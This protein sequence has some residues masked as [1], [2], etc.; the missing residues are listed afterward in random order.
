[1]GKQLWFT[2]S[3]FSLIPGET[4]KTNPGR[5]G[6]ALAVWVKE[7]LN[8]LGYS[9]SEEPIPEDWGWVIMIQRKP[10]MLS[11]GCGNEDGKTNRWMLFVEAE[12]GL[13]QKFF[14]RINTTTSVAGLENQL[15][16]VIR[17]ETQS[18]D[19][20]WEYS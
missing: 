2:T 17:N 8:N 16:D 1:M 12:L 19:I 20:E 4:D 6:L 18:K 15:E 7:K 5:Y 13:F 14:R 11:V 3:E 9:V 10:F